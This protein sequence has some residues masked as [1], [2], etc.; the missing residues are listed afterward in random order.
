MSY[1]TPV[2]YSSL[3]GADDI[4]S[5]LLSTTQSKS[6]PLQTVVKTLA[7][8]SGVAGPN[9]QQLF[10]IPCN[11][12]SG[13]LKSGSAYIRLTLSVT[14]LN[15]ASTWSFKGPVS[16]HN[17][18][19]II[20]KMAVSCGSVQLSNLVNY[21]QYHD[22]MLSHGISADYNAEQAQLTMQGVTKT[23]NTLNSVNT[24]VSLVLPVLSSVIN[25]PQH[26]P[27]WLLSAGLNIEITYSSIISAFRTTG[28]PITS[29]SV[30]GAELIYEEILPSLEVKQAIISKMRES[31]SSWRQYLLSTYS[32]ST[33]SQQ[34]LSYMIG[35]NLQS[36]RNVIVT[37]T[38]NSDN[39]AANH[40]NFQSNGFSGASISLDGRII[41][42]VF[43]S[44]ASTFAELQRC[45]S[46]LYDHTR[47]SNLVVQ[48]VVPDAQVGITDYATSKW[49]FSASCASLNDYSIRFDGMPCSMINVL[50]NHDTVGP[51]SAY[52]STA[53]FAAS[54]A[55]FYVQY[56]E[57][58]S[59]DSMGQISLVR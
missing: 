39:V 10:S 41:S 11:S 59:I 54:T 24:T 14:Q 36:L 23:N 45:F 58:L 42:P 4:S 8:A 19:A 28:N 47:A 29:Y 27:L 37:E 35:V 6:I 51:S 21:A 25:S 26:L 32:L 56:D 33:S 3:L 16:L 46:N 55:Y 50:I 30:S 20:N 52:G 49:G 5:S 7:T 53:S 15:G 57:L 17:G 48:N 34:S 43:N 22:L 31:G 13:Y 2:Q 12:S 44:S 40:L 9:G 38:L 1:F 18:N